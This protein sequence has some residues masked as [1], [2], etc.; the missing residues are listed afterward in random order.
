MD[1][2]R[3]RSRNG[4]ADPVPLPRVGGGLWLCGKH[5]VGP[6]VEEALRKTGATTAVCLNQRRE[7]ADRYP[8]YLEW[9]AANEPARA[10]WFP[11]P[12]LHAPTVEQALPFVEGLVTRV[13]AGEVLLLHCGAGIGRA[14]TLAAAL[15]V[16]LGASL[17]EAVRAVASSRPMAGPEAGPQRDFLEA[18]ARDRSR[19]SDAAST[20]AAPTTK[21][22]SP[23]RV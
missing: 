12:D 2:V 13:T 6:D 1:W 7:L 22:P 5:F 15:L 20:K 14:G 18:F 3:E 9:L 4:G 16:R 23:R 21:G 19:A 8:E 17:E 11:V 10:V